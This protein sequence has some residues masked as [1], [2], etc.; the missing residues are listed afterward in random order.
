MSQMTSWQILDKYSI[1][2]IFCSSNGSV[3]FQICD[4]A[5]KNPFSKNKL[6]YID[7]KTYHGK[8]CGKVVCQYRHFL[9]EN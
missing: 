7:Q 3:S 9:N 8:H 4:V 2:D 1:I 5:L 6:T